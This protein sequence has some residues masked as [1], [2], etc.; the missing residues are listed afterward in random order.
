VHVDHATFTKREIEPVMRAALQ[1]GA[2]GK[3]VDHAGFLR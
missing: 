3:C 1:A 2:A